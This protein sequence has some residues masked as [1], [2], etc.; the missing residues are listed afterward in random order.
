[1]VALFTLAKRWTPR[2]HQWM[3]AYTKCHIYIQENIIAFKKSEILTLVTTWM[4][5]EDI[6]LSEV[7]QLQISLI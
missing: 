7:R 1:M 4:K 5:L 3:N 6:I 2:V